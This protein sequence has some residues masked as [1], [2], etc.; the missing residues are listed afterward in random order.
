MDLR[1]EGVE[2]DPEGGIL[3][4]GN[5]IMSTLYWRVFQYLLSHFFHVL[6]FYK[7]CCYKILSTH[8]TPPVLEED[9]FY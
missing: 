5:A 2:K 8:L 9:E 7:A 4:A 6:P 1:E 3:P